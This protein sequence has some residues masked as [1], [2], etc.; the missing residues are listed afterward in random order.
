[1]QTEIFFQILVLVYSVILHEI[2]HG[3]AAYY[4]GDKTAFY[5]NRLTLNPLPHIDMFGSIILPAILIFTHSPL[6]A[7]WAKPV[8]VN[9]NNLRPQKLGS[10]VVSSAGVL[11]NLFLCTIFILIGANLSSEITKSLCYLIAITNLSLAIFNLIPFPPADGYRIISV[12]LPYHL[13]QKI[14]NLLS[15]YFLPTIL[16]SLFVA[17]Q[18]FSII[19]PYL[20]NLVYTSIFR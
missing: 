19:F 1:M 7:G 6:L 11:V 3:Y 10:F 9:E 20:Q 2:A 18:V 13:N 15:Q 16:I 5:Q 4:F 12:L 17:T 14:E 8:P